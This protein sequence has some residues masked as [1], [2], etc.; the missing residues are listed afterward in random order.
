MLP[1]PSLSTRRH[2][3]NQKCFLPLVTRVPSAPSSKSLPSPLPPLCTRRPGIQPVEE[4]QASRCTLP[5]SPS[6]RL[7]NLFLPFDGLNLFAFPQRPA[8]TDRIYA[9]LFVFLFPYP[10]VSIELEP[11]LPSLSDNS[12]LL[13]PR[14]T[15]SRNVR[16]W[17]RMVALS[18]S[19]RDSENAISAHFCMSLTQARPRTQQFASFAFTFVL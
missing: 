10:A 4:Q 14:A 12:P 1:L 13:L 8:H 11:K 17:L 7:R 2:R 15:W 6:S 19:A 9:F 16:A 18:R 5:P 3:R